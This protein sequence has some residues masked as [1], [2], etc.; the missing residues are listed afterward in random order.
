MSFHATPLILATALALPALAHG[1]SVKSVPARYTSPASGS[2]MYLAYCATCHGAKGLGD[3]PVAGHLKNAVPDLTSLAQRNQG[4][5]PKD[6][7]AKVIRGEESAESHGSQDMPVW[8]PVFRSLN[9]SQ[10]PV[11]RIRVANLAQH[12]ESLQAK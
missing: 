8:G 1:P 9:S 10:E 6:Q 2:E 12:L 4:T 7:V 3:G 5:F 11:V